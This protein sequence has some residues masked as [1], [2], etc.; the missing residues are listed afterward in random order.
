MVVTMAD[1]KETLNEESKIMK[2]VESGDGMT[3]SEIA[4]F[5]G[6]PKEEAGRKLLELQKSGAPVESRKIG[7]TTLWYLLYEKQIKRILIV[8]DD[9][10]INDLE[11]TSLGPGYEIRQ[12]FDGTSGLKEAREWKPDLVILDLMLPGIDGLDICQTLK[13]DPETKDIIV[14][15]VS[16]ADAAKNRFRGIKYGADYYIKKPFRPN[17]L[18]TLTRIFLRKKGRRFD[19]LVDLP[20]ESRISRVLEG[21][22]RRNEQFEVNNLRI[23]NLEGYSGQYGDEEAKVIIRLVSQILQDKAQ[24]WETEN[25]FVGYIG[26]GEFIVAGGEKDTGAV[27]SEVS[28]EFENVLPFLYQDKKIIDVELEGMFEPALIGNRMF[29]KSDI[30]PTQRIRKA[31]EQIIQEGGPAEGEETPKSLG[32]YTYEQ[33]RELVGSKNIDVAITRDASG[34]KLSV[35]KAKKD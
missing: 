35:S 9:R 2:A 18:R 27:V 24:G 8:E 20:D 15:I 32:M 6:I 5:S 14:I 11:K 26:N 16:A 33:L 7:N 19:P 23:A 1:Q 3:E 13:K 12:A 22:I 21:L 25:G 29:I 28:A 4:E 31:R 10:N 17:E 30:V 34:A